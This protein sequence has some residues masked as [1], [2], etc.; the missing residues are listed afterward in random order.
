MRG[1]RRV[2]LRPRAVYRTE[3][4]PMGRTEACNRSY[5]REHA[6]PE[7][8]RPDLILARRLKMPLD[9]AGRDTR[10]YALR[11]RKDSRPSL[12]LPPG[13]DAR[14]AWIESPRLRGY[15]ES[16]FASRIPVGTGVH[17]FAQALF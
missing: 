2:G 9:W 11:G 14:D 5:E 12:L 4:A 16:P 3:V 1:R 15:P 17:F 7:A 6:G 8:V 10:D 13:D